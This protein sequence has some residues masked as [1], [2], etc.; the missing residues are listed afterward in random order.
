MKFA[1]LADIHANA[2]ALESVLH[3]ARAA[4]VEQLIVAGDIVGYYYDAGATLRLLDTF[5]WI[6]VRGNHEEMLRK[7]SASIDR[8]SIAKKYGSGLSHALEQLLPND[9][10]RLLS[11]PH[12]AQL[13]RD[14]KRIFVCHGAP[15]DIDQYIYPDTDMDTRRRLMEIGSDL[16]VFGHTHYPV[17]WRN[18]ATIVVNPG[19]V[20]Q[21]RNG[22]PGAAWC[23]WD[24]ETHEVELRKTPY[25]VRR[26][27]HDASTFDPHLP[28]LAEI[29]HRGEQ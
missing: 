28:Y 18:G 12:P 3:E 22:E 16:I 2:D 24:S 26:I 17:V 14:G 15:W 4:S 6:G 7:W 27:E 19:S 8:E 21:Q 5:P 23:L 1:L 10:D 9:I 11:L 20:G 25:D 13:V 29:L